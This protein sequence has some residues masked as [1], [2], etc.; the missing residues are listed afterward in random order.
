MTEAVR[1]PL[2]KD[3][4]GLLGPGGI[5]V[6]RGGVPAGIDQVVLRVGRALVRSKSQELGGGEHSLFSLAAD[7]GFLGEGFGADIGGKKLG[8]AFFEAEVSGATVAEELIAMTD[9]ELVDADHGRF[10]RDGVSLDFRTGDGGREAMTLKKGGDPLETPFEGA[11][12]AVFIARGETRLPLVHP[13]RI[14]FFDHRY[15]SILSVR[16][17][18]RDVMDNMRSQA[19]FRLSRA[20][21]WPTPNQTALKSVRRAMNPWEM[22]Q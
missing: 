18:C 10:S 6:G 4:D 13:A 15:R 11:D 20:E 22:T 9:E 16:D 21:N 12:N 14:P 7:L 17:D 5:S 1:I 2:R 3:Y 19:A 8:M